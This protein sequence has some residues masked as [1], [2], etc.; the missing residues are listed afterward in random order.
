MAT[1]TFRIENKRLL[2]RLRSRAEDL[3]AAGHDEASAAAIMVAE[4]M[5][6]E[7]TARMIVGWVKVYGWTRFSKK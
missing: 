2:Y 1:V 6:S 7:S 3:L 4:K 5:C